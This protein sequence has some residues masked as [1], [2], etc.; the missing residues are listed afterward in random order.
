MLWLSVAGVAG[1]SA[2][3]AGDAKLISSKGYSVHAPRS[4]TPVTTADCR[5]DAPVCR[6]KMVASG[7][8][9]P[10]I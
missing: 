2:A 6:G 9:C 8:A 1:R 5:A 3:P 10:T 4:A 7:S